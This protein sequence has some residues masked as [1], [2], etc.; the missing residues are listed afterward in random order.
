MTYIQNAPTPFTI[1]STSTTKTTTHKNTYASACLS[2]IN[3][4]IA[5]S[6]DT[7]S[8]NTNQDY[9]LIINSSQITIQS[10][11]VYGTVYAFITLSQLIRYSND[12]KMN[13]IPNSPWNINDYPAIKYRGLMID[14][15]RNYL[16]VPLIKRTLLAMAYNK[17]NVLH[18]HMIDA[19]SFPFYSK[20]HPELSKY[21][22]YG[23]DKIYSPQNITDI[24]AYAKNLG[25]RII[26]EWESPGHDTAIGFGDPDVMTCDSLD[27]NLPT[28]HICYEPPCGY[29]NLLNQ[30]GKSLA[31]QLF[32]DLSKDSFDAFPDNVFHVGGDEVLQNCFGNMTDTIYNEWMVNRISFLRENNK[33]PAI[34]SNKLTLNADYGQKDNDILVISYQGDV[35]KALQAGYKVVDA[36]SNYYYLD[37]G[38]GNWQQPMKNCWC[39]PYRT[40]GIIYNH[41][42]Y[43]YIP[44]NQSQLLKNLWGGEIAVWG[45]TVDDANFESRTWMRSAAAAER[46]WKNTSLTDENV[47]EIYLRLQIQRA[48][49]KYQGLMSGPIGPEFCLLDS[50]YCDA[51]R[52]NDV[53]NDDYILLL[54]QYKLDKFVDI[55]EQEGWDMVR[56]WKEI[57]DE[58]LREWGFKSGDIVKF[59][60]LI[61]DNLENSWL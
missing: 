61:H 13:I 30:T 25:I 21:G 54:K 53:D 50:E 15:G 58:M 42:L 27:D 32:N 22:S 33:I 44:N 8:L 26:P 60:H 47:N 10:T 38:L 17:M 4:Q 59:K 35:L 51:I 5:S 19:Q 48:W 43:D 3:I 7:L 23:P 14:T 18:W 57:D 45:E 36:N 12:M 6:D 56:Y 1:R 40:W 9:K 28:A 46:W 37:C 55:F 29:L 16:S 34:W 11:S 41:S 39:N 2:N 31:I 24:V 20:S 52:G 49:M